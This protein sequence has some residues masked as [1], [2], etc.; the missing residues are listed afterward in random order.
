MELLL[1]GWILAE[2]ADKGNQ[3]DMH[4]IIYSLQ[5]SQRPASIRSYGREGMH[6]GFS[7]PS[8]QNTVNSHSL[9]KN[10]Q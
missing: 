3:K 9:K 2:S 8:D 1:P 7:L 5:D 4:L 10:Q 6:N